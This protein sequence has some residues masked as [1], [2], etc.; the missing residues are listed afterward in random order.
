MTKVEAIEKLLLDN[1]GIATW[2]MIYHEIGKYHPN[3]KR[4]DTWQEGIRGVVYREIRNKRRFKI[5]APGTVSL[6]NYDELKQVL[7]EDRE[8]ATQKSIQAIIRIGQDRFRKSLLSVLKYC[9]ITKIDDKRL[10]NA[11]HIKPWAVSN[12][13]ERLDIHNGFI[14]SPVI[15]RLFDNG[16]I[17]FENNKRLLISESLSKKNVS[18]LGIEN[19]KIYQNLSIE[20][21]T[22]YLEYHR[23]FVFN[24]II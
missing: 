12:D 1:D 7:N 2:G 17:T 9:P 24:R 5:F 3:A 15:D 6:Y 20:N 14:F 8:F 11:S 18:L 19:G 21:R 23:N 4:S 10:L 16:L 13:K 22:G